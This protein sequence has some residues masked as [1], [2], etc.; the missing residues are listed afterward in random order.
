MTK[1][2]LSL[3]KV[4]DMQTMILA[5]LRGGAIYSP[6]QIQ[7]IIDKEMG[8]A[9]FQ[10]SKE[11]VMTTLHDLNRQH[12]IVKIHAR[13]FQLNPMYDEDPIYFDC[14]LTVNQTADAID[15]II[16][17]LPNDAPPE[18]VQAVHALKE[19]ALRMFKNLETVQTTSRNGATFND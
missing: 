1:A 18:R 13:A 15:Q 8:D 12:K 16:D 2:D 4:C 7:R 9:S 14:M 6:R 3:I 10:F 17:N 11:T 5:L 19:H